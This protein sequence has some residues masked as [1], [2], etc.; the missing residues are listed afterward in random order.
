M[1]NR[2]QKADDFFAKATAFLNKNLTP[3]RILFLLGLFF[4]LQTL[5]SLCFNYQ[6]YRDVGGVYAW[7]ARDFGNGVWWSEPL[8]KVPVLN[9]FLGGF[10]VRCGVPPYSSL[11]TL[12]MLFMGL[13]IIPLYRM[14]KLFL[15]A[16]AAAWGCVIFTFAPQMLRFAGCGLLES[17]RDF[18]LVVA[19][20]FLFKNWNR[21]CEL[22]EWIIF[23][24][25]LGFL[26]LARGEGIVMAAAVAVGLFLRQAAEW[27]SLKTILRSVLIPVFVSGVFALVVISPVLIQNYRVTGFPVTEARM[28]GVL[29]AVPGVNKCF[30]EKYKK[31]E[32]DPRILPHAISSKD[33]DRSGLQERLCAFPRNVLRGAYEP[34]FVLAIM[35]VV[36]LI[37]RKQWRREYTFLVAYCLLVSCCFINFSVAHRYF[38]F[39]VPMLMVFTLYAL[40]S[41][42]GA[43]EKYHV[44]NIILAVLVAVCLLQP[45]NAW[46][47]MMDKS[48]K[49][50]LKLRAFVVQNR[51]RFLSDGADRKLIVH[52]DSR[53]LFRCGEERLF[54]YGEEVPE[55]RYITGFDLLLVFKKELKVL[56]D[57]KARS[58]LQQI[59]T[60]FRRFVI[61]VP[62]ERNRK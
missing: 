1:W 52:A 54:Q 56:E 29:K 48:C 37:K 34:Y 41:I 22:Y 61:F 53:L 12:A 6:L 9:I 33:S 51:K 3:K 49:D 43:V 30:A 4:I 57:C 28:I 35:G 18:F 15:P 62:V 19:L 7:Y 58:D 20:Y 40:I 31:A 16:A 23:G 45:L 2:L 59:E 5:F 46:T 14:L 11:I 60:P 44:K 25:A 55:I 21:A 38:V 39:F 42:L 32:S 27:K 10:L 13:T 50:E 36:L 24:L 26:S 8:S 17:T 47:W